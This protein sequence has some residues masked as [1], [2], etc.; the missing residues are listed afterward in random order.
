MRPGGQRR[1]AAAVLLLAGIASAC[2]GGGPDPARGTMTVSPAEARYDVPVAVTVRG[3]PA[4]AR[5][6]I[7]ASATDRTGTA[8]SASADFDATPAGMVS[9]DQ[10]PVGGS[11]SGADP[12]GLFESMVP[13][14]G[15]TEHQAFAPALRYEVA[16]RATVGGR[17]VAT[18]VATRR[19]A[20]PAEVT[21]RELRPAAGD[22]VYG[23]LVTPVDTSVRRPAVLVFS[24]SGG[25]LTRSTDAALLAAH[26][27]PSLSL[28][29]FKVPGLPPT[30]KDVP[31]EYFVRALGV[32][33]RQ[34]GVDPRRVYVMG[35]S[36]GGEAALLLGAYFPDQ[37]NG[38]VAGV[39]SDSVKGGFPVTGEAAWT[40]RGRPLPA[41]S[42]IPVERIR[43][44][45]LLACGGQDLVWSSCL[46]TEAAR[47]RLREAGFRQPVVDLRYPDAGH[48]AGQLV[49]YYTPFTADFIAQSGGTVAATQA[50]LADGERRLLAFLAGR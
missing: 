46:F 21:V 34:P 8:W 49:T 4:G 2:T 45:V 43:G 15:D 40:L 41:G 9:L 25:G 1:P 6:T 35:A 16:L 14:A 12:M 42:L 31:L 13:P 27:Y 32:L 48:G 10:P 28:A 5:T 26:G 19:T 44:P 50:A 17:E 7:T 30:L 18:A 29:Y 37:V 33:R 3:L 47:T 38:V 24:G 11:Y 23:D 39:P 22:P 20:T 36:R